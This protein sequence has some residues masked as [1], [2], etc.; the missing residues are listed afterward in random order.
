MGK[1]NKN[2]T[3]E[4][5]NEYPKYQA[6]TKVAAAGRGYARGCWSS[7]DLDSQPWLSCEL[8]TCIYLHKFLDFFPPQFSHLENEKI[9]NIYF[10][11]L[12]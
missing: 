7:K 9:N 2:L 8:T 11:E 1:A 6:M 5:R 4:I 10:I 12:W 3:M